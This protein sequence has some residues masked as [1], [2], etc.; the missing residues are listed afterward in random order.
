MENYCY[1][2]DLTE[3]MQL[4]IFRG[5]IFMAEIYSST[6]SQ[7]K[8][9]V[10]VVIIQNDIGNRYSPNVIVATITAR[11][12]KNLVTHININLSKPST[13]L[14]ED[15]HTIKKSQLG[16]W[17]GRLSEEELSELD[18][19]LMKSLGIVWIS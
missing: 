9:S 5:D 13:I 7:E 11:E 14:C 16:N 2:V 6:C 18:S 3:S 8:W 4:K 1:N 17:M 15:I 12:K 19:T 10:P